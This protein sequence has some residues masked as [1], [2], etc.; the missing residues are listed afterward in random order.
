MGYAYSYYIIYTY[1]CGILFTDGTSCDG[2]VFWKQRCHFDVTW[3][4]M[5]VT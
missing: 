2:E 1:V 5:E 4:K 3:K